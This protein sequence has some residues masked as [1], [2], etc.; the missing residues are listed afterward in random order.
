MEFMEQCASRGTRNDPF[1]ITTAKGL[2]SVL[3][4]DA[5]LVRGLLGH[6]TLP[7]HSAIN[8]R[9]PYM[10]RE[11]PTKRKLR[12]LFMALAGGLALI[13]PFLIMILVSGQ[14]ARIIALVAFVVAFAFAMSVGSELTPDRLAMVTA[15][16]AAALVVFVG[17][18]P[19]TYGT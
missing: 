13:V 18:N 3:L 1:L 17:T 14:L 19:P 15:A 5:G 8:Q 10:K 2:E 9:L 16:Y 11:V 6:H 4:E 12:G 7:S